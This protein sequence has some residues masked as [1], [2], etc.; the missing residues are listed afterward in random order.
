MSHFYGTVR[1]SANNLATRTGHPNSGIT[2]QACS[3]YGAIEVRVFVDEKDN[4]AF[5]IKRIAWK[6]KGKCESIA[7][8]T[9]KDT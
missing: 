3:W 6:G 4:D 5:E 8:G 9:F 7:S 1:G 2:T